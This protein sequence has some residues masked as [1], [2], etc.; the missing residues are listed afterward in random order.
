MPASIAD[1]GQWLVVSTPVTS[2]FT[3]TCERGPG[4]AGF[5][6]MARLAKEKF[7]EHDLV[8]V[9]TSGH[10]IGHGGMEHFM[11]DGA[12]PP[13]S[14]AAWAHFGS[15]LAC[16]DPVVTAINSSVSMTRTVERCFAQVEGARFTGEKA[17]IGELRDV[18]AANY[19]HFFGMA[20]SHKYFHTSADSLAAVDPALLVPMAKAFADTLSAVRE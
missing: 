15:S 3:S 9:A 4:I 16:R 13:E 11:R 20:G 17:A 19:R 18:Y 1:D 7:T 10:E 14:T 2:W 5:L 6:A 12:P 8:F